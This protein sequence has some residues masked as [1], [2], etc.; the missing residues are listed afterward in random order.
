[1]NR[2]TAGV[3]MRIRVF[4][5]SKW[6]NHCVVGRIIS[7]SQMEPIVHKTFFFFLNVLTIKADY[8]SAMQLRLFNIHY[9]RR[10]YGD[11]RDHNHYS[12]SEATL[13]AVSWGPKHSAVNKH[14]SWKV[15]S[16]WIHSELLH[17]T[18]CMY[19]TGMCST[20][21]PT[22]VSRMQHQPTQLTSIFWIS[23]KNI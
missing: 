23:E 12:S 18:C 20:G 22:N 4:L 19:C 1:M 7:S 14:V 8:S 17:G 6:T 16:K 2:G 9:V 10:Q 21:K 3:L 5:L 15:S 13:K 11:F